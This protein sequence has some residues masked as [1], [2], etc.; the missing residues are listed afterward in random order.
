MLLALDDAGFAALN[1]GESQAGFAVI[2]GNVAPPPVLQMLR[3]LAATIR[4]D[5]APCA[6]AMMEEGVVLGLLSVVKP[7]KD[8]GVIEIGYGV[9]DAA[10]GRGVCRRAVADLI[11]WARDDGRVSLVRAETGIAN[12]ASQR[13]LET[14]GFA[15]VGQRVDAEDG[16]LL[17]WERAV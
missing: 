8:D 4:P 10:Q 16:E 3:D 1:D 14:N 12:P 5:F 9:A 13:V 15:V 17:I 11:H 6:W 7:P 2:D